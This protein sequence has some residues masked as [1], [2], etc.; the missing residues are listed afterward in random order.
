MAKK[1]ISIMAITISCKGVVTPRTAPN[2]MRT[3]ADAKSAFNILKRNGLRR[4]QHV[5]IFNE[6]K[7][8]KPCDID[9]DLLSIPS[10]IKSLTKCGPLQNDGGD[11]EINRH[12]RV[13]VPFEKCHQESETDKHHHVNILK[14]YAQ[15][16]FHLNI[17]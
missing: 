14:H 8:I 13:A 16:Q 10:V 17:N 6:I 15:I 4:Q 3:L 5:I 11:E 7:L 12:G 1:A 9:A 2:E